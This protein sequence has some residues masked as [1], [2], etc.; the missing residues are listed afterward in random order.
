MMGRIPGCSSFCLQVGVFLCV[1]ILSLRTGY[2]TYTVLAMPKS[3]EA[4]CEERLWNQNTYLL[5]VVYKT[6]I[7][8]NFSKS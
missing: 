6:M 8:D 3:K 5:Q 7:R 1:A 2:C 4:K